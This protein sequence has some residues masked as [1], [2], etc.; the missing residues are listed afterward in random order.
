MAEKARLFMMYSRVDFLGYKGVPVHWFVQYREKPAYS[1]EEMIN[2]YQGLLNASKTDSVASAALDIARS[3]VDE[4]FTEEE[5]KSL[6][7]YLLDT[8]GIKS[9]MV[10]VP[11]PMPPTMMPAEALPVG[12]DSG[13]YLLCDEP[14]YVLPFDV[15]GYYDLLISSSYDPSN[16]ESVQEWRSKRVVEFTVHSIQAGMEF[17]DSALELGLKK[18]MEPDDLAAL[19]A[20]LYNSE[21]SFLV[22]MAWEDDEEW[23]ELWDNEDWEDEDLEWGNNGS[24]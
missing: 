20:E 17:L 16:V 7:K 10:S 12:D 11:L 19:V 3:A 13:L 15:W 18:D 8:H 14:A 9:E 1:Y 23:D 21:E 4:L 2:G 24:H 5:A 6:R 22:K